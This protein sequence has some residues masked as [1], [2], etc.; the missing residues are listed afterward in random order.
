[1]SNTYTFNDYAGNALCSAKVTAEI[2]NELWDHIEFCF[3]TAPHED[4]KEWTGITKSTIELKIMPSC[5][6]RLPRPNDLYLSQ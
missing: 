3:L 1:M 6:Y 5:R 4:P 2:K